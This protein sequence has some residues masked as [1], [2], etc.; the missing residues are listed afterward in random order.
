[1]STIYYVYAYLRKSDGTPYYI[2]KGK[3]NRAYNKSHTVT[4]PKDRSK[5]VLLETNL[6]EI[7]AYALERRYIRWYGRKDNGTGVLHNKTDGGEGTSGLSGELH[8][9]FGKPLSAEQKEHLSR[10]N[11][12]KKIPIGIR[13]KISDT[14][15]RNYTEE[16][17]KKLIERMSGINNPIYG[18]TRTE[19]E[20]NKIRLSNSKKPIICNQTQ[21]IFLSQMEASKVMNIKQGD[22]NNMLRGRQK[23]VKGYS[24][25]YI[26]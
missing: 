4:V 18:R 11:S 1:M 16:R 14:L 23:T 8:Y 3:G 22:I 2:G 21:Q 24:F 12:G 13:K 7:G 20:K 15:K 9:A 26:E 17:R 6:T 19:E 5:I 25:S 10:I